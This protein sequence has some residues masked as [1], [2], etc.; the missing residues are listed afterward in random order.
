[1]QEWYVG[2]FATAG[3]FAENLM[4]MC[5]FNA[6]VLELMERMEEVNL[7]LDDPELPPMVKAQVVLD[8]NEIQQKFSEI[9]GSLAIG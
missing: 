8:Y 1:M 5:L 3:S 6:A 7:G 9:S 2:P 4:A